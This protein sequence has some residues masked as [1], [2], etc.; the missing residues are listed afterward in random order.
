MHQHGVE[1]AA[2]ALDDVAE[3][4]RVVA[5][6]HDVAHRAYEARPRPCRAHR[7]DQRLQLEAKG[8]ARKRI[9]LDD[10]GIRP[11]L[12]KGG[13][14]R[15]APPVAQR[16]V[17][18]LAGAVDEREARVARTHRRQLHDV[19]RPILRQ[20]DRLAAADQRHRDAVLRER[21]GDAQRA[22]QVPD[23]EQM[24]NVEQYGR[25][26]AARARPSR[27]ITAASR[28]AAPRKSCSRSTLMRA[29][30]PI[31]ARAPPSRIKRRTAAA[32]ARDIA[33][34]H[35]QPGFPRDDDA[36]DAAARPG[37]D[38]QTARLRFEE[39]HAEGFVDRRPDEQVGL[40]ESRRDRGVIERAA[41]ANSRAERGQRAFD[42][43]AG[44]A[45]AD[46]V[47]RPAAGRADQPMPRR[48]RG[49][50]RACRRAASSPPRS[51]GAAMLAAGPAA[52]HS[53]ARRET[54]TARSSAADRATA[55]ARMRGRPG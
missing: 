7:R 48:A 28:V 45:V 14:Q 50:R 52:R 2:H 30:A 55:A 39:R 26:H 24:L 22:L 34:R 53:A 42:L 27:S 19:N 54:G 8:A 31:A 25:G 23:T 20:R 37:H 32:K 17:D 38:R 12:G 49:R 41:V 36:A 6:H 11:S 43:G 44:R 9:P 47:E 4:L 21:L 13:E 35:E 3:P 10:H 29:A 51:G 46:N 5:H 15:R 33:G 16:V 40:G 1:I 18:R